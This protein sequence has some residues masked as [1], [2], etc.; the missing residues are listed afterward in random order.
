MIGLCIKCTFSSRSNSTASTADGQGTRIAATHASFFL[1]LP[2]SL[3]TATSTHR[4]V[5][6]R[7]LLHLHHFSTLHRRNALTLHWLIP[8]QLERPLSLHSVNQIISICN[9]LNETPRWLPLFSSLRLYN[10]RRPTLTILAGKVCGD[11]H[12]GG[13]SSGG[14]C[15]CVNRRAI[16]AHVNDSVS[17]AKHVGDIV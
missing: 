4:R 16:L 8:R 3:S 12:L 9:S 6:L 13:F 11:R 5:S 1:S 14:E 7:V 2:P 17:P 10:T 15:K